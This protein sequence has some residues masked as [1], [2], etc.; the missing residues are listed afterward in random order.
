ARQRGELS[1]ARATLVSDHVKDCFACRRAEREL[2]EA[3][4]PKPAA[5]VG[6]G[7][8]W[9]RAAVA[10]TL[11]GGLA[12]GAWMMRDLTL[13]GSEVE[14]IAGQLLVPSSGELVTS[15]ASVAAGTSLRTPPGEGAIL[16][17]ADGSRIELDQ[18]SSLTV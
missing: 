15:G 16:Q 7:W 14:I 3:A 9:M 6:S 11:I 13:A 18:R 2:R 1:P 10:A 4:L 17:L 5:A 12:A 8:N